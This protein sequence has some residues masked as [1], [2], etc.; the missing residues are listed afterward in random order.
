MSKRKA[1]AMYSVAK[2]PRL[3]RQGGAYGSEL[4]MYSRP[5][6]KGEMKYFDT[7]R[8]AIAIATST[9]W[10][11]TELD[12]ATFNCLFAPIQGAAIN[13]RIGRE[14]KVMK[15][16]MKGLIQS[17]SQMDQTAGD[18]PCVIRLILVQDM[19][20]NGSQAQGEDVMATTA[21]GV[22]NTCSFLSLA[23]LGRFRVL[24]DKTLIIENPNLSWDGTNLEQQ[25]VAKTFKWNVTFRNPVSVRF[26][27]TNGGTIADIVDNSFHLIGCASNGSLSPSL[28]YVCRV[29]YKE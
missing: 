4:I 16:K 14:V 12:P 21:N 11:G 24:K 8:D 10:T 18:P 29:C 26:N 6:I 13:Q 1:E 20:T 17:T 2:K 9:D 7:Q 5:Q 27:S 3:E 19:Q 23:S 25:G 22:T 28:H 15:I